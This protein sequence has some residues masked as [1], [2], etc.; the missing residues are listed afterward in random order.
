MSTKFPQSDFGGG[1]DNISDPIK[2]AADSYEYLF[3]GRSRFSVI[4]TIK[5][6]RLLDNAPSGNRQGLY[7]IGN[8]MILFVS[9]LAYYYDTTF[10]VWHKINTFLMDVNVDTIYTEFVNSS[11]A[12]AVRKMNSSGSNNDKILKTYDFTVS[13]NPAGLVC[14]DGINQ[15][16]LI[17]LNTN[18]NTFSARLCKTYDQWSNT[19]I[20]ANDREYVPIG[21]QM[22]YINDILFI[23]APD[24]T[25]IYRSVSGRPLDFMVNIDVSGNKGASEN[26][27]GASSVGFSVG[28]QTITAIREL[29]ADAFIIATAHNVNIVSFDYI[30]T[31]FGEPTF[32]FPAKMKFGIV[33]QFSI[34]EFKDV[35]S[36]DFEG[37]TS[38][39]AVSQLRFEGCNSIFS[40]NMSG[41][42][43]DIR[44]DVCCCI[45]FNNYIHFG[46]KSTLGYVVMIYDILKDSW[47]A[48][49]VTEASK[50]KMFAILTTS[51][52]SD[53]EN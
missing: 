51:L 52:N 1:Q 21:K 13:G 33:N 20:T 4:D 36:I 15:P 10:D 46:V 28:S 8:S 26:L 50:V 35:V 12:N 39:N 45:E 24:G 6:P 7:A 5:K 16:W 49:D 31:I 27:T 9:G 48:I 53:I 34:S 29:G 14:Q 30:N 43:K 40:L 37:V 3:N 19:S 44:Q 42:F 25:S 23:I 41:F 22:L 38:F 47:A 11:T 17:Q 18:T 32:T 2:I